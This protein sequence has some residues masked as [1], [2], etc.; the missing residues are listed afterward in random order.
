MSDI[1]LSAKVIFI[2][3]DAGVKFCVMLHH[4]LRGFPGINIKPLRGPNQVKW[5]INI[6]AS[7]L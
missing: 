3:G 4:S 7:V 1:Q 2:W 5:L 6:V